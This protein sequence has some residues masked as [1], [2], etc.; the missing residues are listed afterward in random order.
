TRHVRFSPAQPTALEVRRVRS[1]Q[2][3]QRRPSRDACAARLQRRA[4]RLRRAGAEATGKPRRLSPLHDRGEGLLMSLPALQ[5][6]ADTRSITERVNVL[7]RHYNN[8]PA[9]QRYVPPGVVL[10]FAGTTAP[11]GFLLCYGQAVS[12]ATYAALFAA[13]GT[14]WGAGD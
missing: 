7:I 8:P 9:A 1:G 4:A 6:T 12:R 11:T 2:Q 10:P 3:R 13:I 5:P 14:S